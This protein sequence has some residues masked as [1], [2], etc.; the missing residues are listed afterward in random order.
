MPDT[1]PMRKPNNLIHEKSP[2]L[3][4]HA[5]NPVNW[6]AWS[7]EA[8]A[9]A[10]EEDKPIFLSIGYSTCHWCHV[11]EHESFE[12]QAVAALMNDTF[13]SIKVDR[14]ERPDIDKTFMQIAQVMTGRGGWPLTIF[15]TPDKK[16]FYAD[17][18]IP[19]TATYGRPGL[20]ELIPRIGEL[21]SAD[22]ENIADV[23]ERVKKALGASDQID[24]EKLTQD[25]LESAY[26]YYVE[27]FDPKR[28]GFGTAPKFPSPHNLMFLLRYW[29]RFNDDWA[30]RMVEKTLMNMRDGGIFDQLGFGF[31]RYST[32]SEWRVPH[33]EKMLYDQAM[34]IMAYSEA[35]QATGNEKYASVVDEL[36][37]YIE[38]KLKSPQG[39]FYSAEDADSEGEEGKFYVWTDEEIRSVL[40]EADADIFGRIFNIR[41][42]GNYL[43]ESAGEQMR[44]NIPYKTTGV[45]DIASALNMEE[46]D[47]RT[48]V[49]NC[50]QRLLDKREL[51]V[52]PHLDDKILTDWNGLAIAALTKASRALGKAEYLRLAEGAL[53]FINQKLHDP[54]GNLLHRYR[55]GEAIIPAFLDDYAFLSWALIELYET[56]FSIEYLQ[57]ALTYMNVILTRFQDEVD[58][59]FFFSE[60]NEEEGLSRQVDA[61]DGAIPSGNSITMYNMIRL[62][63][64]LGN[65][66]LEERANRIGTRFAQTIRRTRGGFS[67]LLCALDY[68]IGPTS[69]VVISGNPDSNDTLAL[70]EIAS[71][72][73]RPSMT[74]LLRGTDE[75]TRVISQL[76]PYTKFHTPQNGIA[77]AY[78]CIEQNC[79]LPTTDA[80]SLRKLLNSS[81]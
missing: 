54:N 59:A 63:R 38:R 73:F 69:E 31:H 11:M 24:S 57:Q 81:V 50:R 47:L 17:T 71:N 52:H 15:M 56:T 10:R 68:S 43:D 19:K 3:L 18:Y 14:E 21:W 42:E 32:D 20:I 33:F 55:D 27:Q 70:L 75:Q 76:A 37:S 53:E 12:D 22:R 40:G 2:Y 74:L 61:Y 9:R 64:M 77:T 29:M 41:K 62:G 6:Y 4:Q 44:R 46:T 49:E 39:A 26:N 8:F 58:R 60:E 1:K 16:P 80:E 35:F 65:L 45:L 5:Y 36:V 34:L 48:T 25:D 79:K 78:V 7:E 72:G 30:L 23:T 13:I 28:G 67:M 51:R 66:E